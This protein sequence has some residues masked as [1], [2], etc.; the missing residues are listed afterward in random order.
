MFKRKVNITLVFTKLSSQRLSHA[1]K[2]TVMQY[3]AHIQK[4]SSLHMFVFVDR[5]HVLYKS[6]EDGYSKLS[7][8]LNTK[9]I[10]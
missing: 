1:T 5:T 9:F 4:P 6:G 10:K 2:R 3:T 8:K 7:G